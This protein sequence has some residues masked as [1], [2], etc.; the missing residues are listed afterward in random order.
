MHIITY[1]EFLRIQIQNKWI[2]NRIY[3]LNDCDY[4]YTMHLMQ[5]MKSTDSLIMLFSN[6]IHL[7]CIAHGIHRILRMYAK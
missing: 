1:L 3:L 7:L 2:K 5:L 4:C 6:L